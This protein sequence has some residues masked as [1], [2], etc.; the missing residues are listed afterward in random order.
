MVNK[1]SAFV[2]VQFNYSSSRVPY[3]LV[4]DSNSL[5]IFNLNSKQLEH[6]ETFKELDKNFIQH[7]SYAPSEVHISPTIKGVI[8]LVVLVQNRKQFVIELFHEYSREEE[9]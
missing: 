7:I 8:E 3:L 2:P 9:T 5:V 6:R 4:S 1:F